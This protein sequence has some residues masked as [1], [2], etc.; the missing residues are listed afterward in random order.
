MSK[1]TYTVEQILARD[2]QV[3]LRVQRDGLQMKKVMNIFNNF[4]PD[5]VGVITVSRRNMAGVKDDFIIDGWHRKEAAFRT[6]PDY[7]LTCHVF[8]GLTV[9]EEALMF[10]NLN[11]TS[12]PTRLEKFKVRLEADDPEAT[13][14]NNI[15]TSLGWSVS[16]APS[17]GHIQAVAALERIHALS[18][19][20]E[21]EPHLLDLTLRTTTKAWGMNQQASQAV[22]L[23]G[24][25]RVFAEYGSRINFARLFEKLRE[26][27]GGP[28]ALHANARQ[29]ASMRNGRTAMAVAELVVETYNS[30]ARTKALPAWGRKH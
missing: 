4:N 30:G 7:M 10:L 13:L 19:K 6:D 22:I 27:K 2:L 28:E 20:V 23:E 14:I 9:P 25:A 16:P 18:Q 5:A 17:N 3:D 29:L 21:A 24:I 12:Q 26:R 8:E 15:V 11:Y 1:T